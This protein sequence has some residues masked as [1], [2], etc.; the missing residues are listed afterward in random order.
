MEV[1]EEEEGEYPGAPEEDHQEEDRQEEAHLEEAHPE[2]DRP[3]GGHLGEEPLPQH[4]RQRPRH[5]QLHQ[6]RQEEM[7]TCMEHPQPCSLEITK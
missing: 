7:G 3:E 2:E 4:L 1:A 6:R 5:L